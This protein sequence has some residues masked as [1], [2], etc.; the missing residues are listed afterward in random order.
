M[1]RSSFLLRLSSI[2]FLVFSVFSFVWVCVLVLSGTLVAVFASALLGFAI[3]LAVVLNYLST[4]LQFS[5]GCRGLSGRDLHK[6]SR[7]GA[8]ILIL[9]VLSI[10]G[11]LISDS[12]TWTQLFGLVLPVLYLIGV[13]TAV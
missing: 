10:L 13:K 6:C 2:L 9:N 1:R 3:I 8:L 11:Y 4:I 5:A 12:F 7:L